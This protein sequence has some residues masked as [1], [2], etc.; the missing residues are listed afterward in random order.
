[1]YAGQGGP[2][3]PSTLGGHACI[4]EEVVLK[5]SVLSLCIDRALLV[6]N[7]GVVCG[8]PGLLHD[9]FLSVSS[10]NTQA[11]CMLGE[12]ERQR[13]TAPGQVLCSSAL[14]VRQDPGGLSPLATA[15]PG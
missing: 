11:T 1:M 6:G 14:D 2:V 8:H 12:S 5:T 13:H 4:Q 15:L 3:E 9:L 7:V 10:C